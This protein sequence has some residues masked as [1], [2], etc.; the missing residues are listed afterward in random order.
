MT[1]RLK[2]NIAISLVFL[3]GFSVAAYAINKILQENARD[4]ILNTAG[5]IMES[6]HA[7]RN[8][9]INEVRPA[10]NTYSTGEFMPQ[11][12]PAYAATRN[13]EGLRK[14]YPEYSYKEATLNPTNPASRA[15]DWE[16][17]VVN[18]FRDNRNADELVGERET[19]TG[20][21]FY[22]ARPITVKQE[23]CL[24][25]HGKID[26]APQSMLARY[27]SAN[28][29]GWKMEEVIG[30]Q[31][32]SVPMSLSLARA[33]EVFHTFL[34]SLAA[35]YF[36]LL[37]LVNILLHY[38]VIRPVKRMAEIASEVSLGKMDAPEFESKGKDELASLSESFSRMRRSLTNAMSLLDD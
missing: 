7:V 16:A 26:D 2:F 31:I 36:S 6:A 32:V 9:T 4:E 19:A 13:I 21:S 17:S 3:L 8:Y 38:I 35:V 33:E 29:F 14:K 25:C 1:L 10:L 37:I 30:S 34:V 23:A 20:P 27:G 28:G 12:V 15:T 18:Y 5:L 22:I 11:T 24:S